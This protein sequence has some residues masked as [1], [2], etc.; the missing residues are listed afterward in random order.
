[1][2]HDRLWFFAAARSVKPEETRTTAAPTLISYD[3]VRDQQRYE[4][5]LTAT[6]SPSH[7]LLG[8]YSKINDKENG[9]SFSTILDEASLVNRETPQELWSVN[10]TGTFTD[11]LLLTAQYSER[12]F[13][14][15][16]S[17]APTTDLIEGTLLLDRSRNSARYHSPT[18]CGVCRPED[19]NNK[20]GLAKLSYFIST[21]SMGSH[22]LVGGYDT[23]DDIRAADNHQSGSDWRILG[24]GALISGANISPIFL[25]DG[26]TFI[27]F[28][29]ILQATQ[30]T[31]FKTNSFF[32]NDTWRLNDRMT[33]GIGLRYDKNDGENEAHQ[34]VADDA[35]FSPRLSGTYDAKGDG[36]LLL[37]ASYGQYVAALANTVADSS[38]SAGVPSSFQWFYRGPDLVGLSQDEAVRRL[39]DWFAAA[40]GG[41]PT[42][43]NP[44][45]GGLQ[46]LRAAAIRGLNTKINGTLD[47]PNVTEYVLGATARIG[48]RGVVRADLVY[49][50]W[51]NF[52]AQR[53]DL[54]TG[55]VSGQVG[56]VT[57]TFDLTLVENNDSLY[58]RTYKGL[59]T[60]FSFRASDR[61]NLGGNWTLSKTDGN[62]NG[63]NQGSGPLAGGLGNYPQYF[64]VSW[65][66]P[67]GPLNIDQRHRVNLYGVYKIFNH[68]RHNLSASLLQGYYSGHPYDANGAI[69]ITPYVNNPGYVTPPTQVGYYFSKRGAFRT[70]NVLR[71]DVSLNYEFR[72]GQVNLFVKPEVIN[73]FNQSKIDTTDVRYFDTTVLT[74]ANSAACPNSPTGRCL[75]FNPFTETPVEGVN[76]VK[77]PNFGKAI[78]ALGFQQPRLYRFALGVRF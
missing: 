9:N 5:K 77:G 76:W 22:D 6:L 21:Q 69:L 48:N 72:I 15:I 53:T 64:Q 49:R 23:Y 63:E 29:P 62:F 7:S 35:S 38:S 27:Q 42:V 3:N 8:S 36:G 46:P 67:D 75:P 10:Y 56:G 13:T 51:G 33:F 59:H 70:S 74:A 4:G 2:V 25:G 44:L 57:Q 31:S 28:D 60:Q 19:R 55:R 1:M 12:K 16:G 37:H 66:S 18:F 52:Y 32:V 11:N 40:N 71:T 78:N 58:K 39:F 26:T 50:D 43:S 14:F 61:L 30:G 68:D 17:G 34:K 47:S 41:L 65:N 54:S 20:N 24:T 73:L 45:G